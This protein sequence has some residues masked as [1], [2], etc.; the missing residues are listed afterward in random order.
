MHQDNPPPNRAIG[1]YRFMLWLMPTCIALTT[2][3]GFAWLPVGRY[4]SGDLLVLG[5][6]VLNALATVGIA[7]FEAKLRSRPD[8]PV[9]LITD[10][11]WIRFFLLQVLIVPALSFAL[12]FALCLAGGIY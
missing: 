1:W 8:R 9:S 7:I 3:Y 11:G 4:L 2:A 10:A 5:W 6:F 12:F